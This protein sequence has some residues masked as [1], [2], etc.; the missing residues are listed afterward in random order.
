MKVDFYF[1]FYFQREKTIQECKT[2]RLNSLST[3]TTPPHSVPF[4]AVG[5]RPPQDETKQWQMQKLTLMGGPGNVSCH[6][7]ADTS[8]SR[9]LTPHIKWMR[10]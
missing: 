10:V 5:Q 7:I 2:A 3:T 8:K 6:N 1:T 4:P 9:L